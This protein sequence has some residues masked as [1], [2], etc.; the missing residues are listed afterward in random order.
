MLTSML[1]NHRP[2]QSSESFIVPDYPHSVASVTI[3]RIPESFT[4]DEAGE[5]LSER[6]ARFCTRK[7]ICL[8]VRFE[9]ISDSSLNVQIRIEGELIPVGPDTRKP[10]ES[11]HV[12][13]CRDI[14]P[15]D[16]TADDIELLRSAL[17]FLE[18]GSSE[19]EIQK[20]RVDRIRRAS[21]AEGFT[22]PRGIR[23]DGLRQSRYDSRRDDKR[24][25]L[26][27]EDPEDVSRFM[28]ADY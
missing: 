26:D 13:V 4:A 23:I 6:L 9:T 25:R 12:I 22:L 11:Y 27:P 14:R 5:L 17:K 8:S 15:D 16:G 20:G 19:L 1:M 7:A 21:F 24:K 3:T 10:G 28:L 2:F 18:V